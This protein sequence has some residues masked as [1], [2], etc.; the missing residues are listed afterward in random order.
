MAVVDPKETADILARARK[1]DNC[2]LPTVFGERYCRQHLAEKTL[3][4]ARAEHRRGKCIENEGTAA[5]CQNQ[6]VP[7]S[8]FCLTHGGADEQ[9]DR[10]TGSED[11]REKVNHPSHYGGD[12]PYEVIKIINHYELNFDLGCVVKYVLRAGKKDGEPTIDDLKKA[13]W[14]LADEIKKHEKKENI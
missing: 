12:N 9:L 6:T 3:G 5:Q 2:T 10:R 14:Y 7:G 8:A 4:V 11:R 1:C 13:A